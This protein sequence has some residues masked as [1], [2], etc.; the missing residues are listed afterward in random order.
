MSAKVQII[1]ARRKFGIAS[2]VVRF[3]LG[4]TDFFLTYLLHTSL[5]FLRIFKFFYTL[6]KPRHNERRSPEGS[7]ERATFERPQLNS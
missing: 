7:G 2:E 1:L 6:A 3:F 5:T 4:L